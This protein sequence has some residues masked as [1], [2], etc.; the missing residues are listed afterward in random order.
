MRSVLVAILAVAAV[1]GTPLTYKLYD[2]STGALGFTMQSW[3]WGIDLRSTEIPPP[4][5]LTYAAKVQQQWNGAL[6]LHGT[7]AIAWG[8]VTGIELYAHGGNSGAGQDVLL[9]AQVAGANVGNQVSLKS[10]LGKPGLTA[11]WQKFTFPASG[12]NL[13]PTLVPNTLQVMVAGSSAA[14]FTD[15]VLAG[16][17][18]QATL[19]KSVVSAGRTVGS[20]NQEIFG[21][22]FADAPML[23][24][25]LYT[26]NR[27]GGNAVTRYS[28][29]LDSQNHAADW[30]FENIANDV[31]NV[32][33]LPNG[34]SSDAFV[35]VTLKA[36]ARTVLTLPTIGWSPV[37]RVR[38][39]G[40]SV[41]KYG[42]QQQTDQWAPDCGNGVKSD[43]TKITGNDPRDTSYPVGA[44]Y[45]NSWLSHLEGIFGPSFIQNSL[46]LFDNEPNYWAGTH[47]DVHPN[48]LSYDELWTNTLQYAQGVLSRYPNAQLAG[49]DIS[50]WCDLIRSP[51]DGSC[52]DGADFAA[53]GNVPL[54]EWY[55]SKIGEHY[56]QTGVKLLQYLDVHCYPEG[57]YSGTDNLKTMVNL[58]S[59]RELWDPTY[60]SSGWH[61][62]TTGLFPMLHAAIAKYAPWL[63]IS[64]TEFNYDFDDSSVVNSVAV[65]EAL[66]IFAHERVDLGTRWVSP[67][68]GSLGEAS[69]RLFRNYDGAGS[70]VA[71]SVVEATTSDVEAATVYAFLSADKATLWVFAA[72][73]Q[74][75]EAAPISVD[76]S[77]FTSSAT[78][79]V[80][81][82]DKDHHA[83]RVADAKVSGGVL[84]ASLTPVSAT[85]FELK[86]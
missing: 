52:A 14:Y 17:F 47:R 86:K 82:L 35:D 59:T 78:A 12:F 56:T 67:A 72:C 39:C 20:V 16:V 18:H 75:L 65:A 21:V 60:P 6:V 19:V 85:L 79:R 41:A 53:H 48:P 44:D 45:L 51:K 32:H 61:G 36:G 30:F 62:K 69:Y 2:G 29:D 23:A 4:N 37:D 1:L 40:F 71:G 15:I 38:R 31:A 70:R 43:G 57:A 28:W 66:A 76:V 25:G 22:N 5:G 7:V 33:N 63:K 64:C 81:V 10:T 46:F 73:K 11:S 84:S 26:A 83:T 58:R 49:P 34:S 54:I 24:T 80:F 8:D 13:P 27:W 74:P 3:G 55:I 68:T 9:Q 50:G 77:S 42:A